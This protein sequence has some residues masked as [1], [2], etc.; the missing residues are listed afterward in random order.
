M[1][2]INAR[3]VK[4]A[5]EMPTPADLDDV[6]ALSEV[7]EA[8]IRGQWLLAVVAYVYGDQPQD[9]P[10]FSVELYRLADWASIEDTTYENT[11]QTDQAFYAD[12][13]DAMACFMDTMNSLI[14]PVIV[15]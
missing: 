6:C 1:K 15:I 9:T 14:E 5:I 12:Q 2:H 11:T 10:V 4:N 13:K 8:N 7:V 3:L